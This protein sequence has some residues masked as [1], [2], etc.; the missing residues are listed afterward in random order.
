[1][2]NFVEKFLEIGRKW[3]DSIRNKS[4]LGF[5]QP[6]VINGCVLVFKKNRCS[7]SVKKVS[8][9]CKTQKKKIEIKSNFPKS[10]RKK[11]IQYFKIQFSTK[12]NFNEK[13]KSHFPFPPI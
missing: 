12:N 7:K 3:L 2:V 9:P 11:Y 8:H 1:L 4:F 5:G 13:S 6:K 10:N